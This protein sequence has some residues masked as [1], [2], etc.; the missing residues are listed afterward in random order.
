MA[1][2]CCVIL[3]LPG[4][5]VHAQSAGDTASSVTPDNFV[6]PLQNLDGAVVFTGATGTQAPPGSENIGITLSG[7]RLNGGLPQMAQAGAAL[8]ERLTRGRIPVAELFDA[9]AK[10]EEDYAN[11]GF[12]LVRV[13]LPQQSLRDGGVLQVVVVNG[14]VEAVDKTNV[15]PEIERRLD[16]LTAPLVDRTD[17]TLAELERQL[18]LA[19]DTAGVSLGSA[20]GAGRAPG[21]TVLTLDPEYRKITGF[22][23]F[24]NNVSDNLGALTLNS[25]VE[26]NSPFGFGETFYLRASGTPDRFT[27]SD[28]RFRV[29]AAG[30]LMPLGTSG[31]ALNG[32][33][34]ASD[35][36]PDDPVAP[37]RSNFDRQSL[38]LI[39]PVIRSRQINVTTQVV[40]DRQH[41]RQDLIA[42]GGITPIYEDRT[43]ALRFGGSAN[44][45]HA[46]GAFSDVGAVLSQGLDALGAR[47]LDE[48]GGGT[49]LSR[50]GADAEFSKLSFS[51]F[52]QRALAENVS[53][54]V[55]ARA[56]FAFG[57]PLVTSEQFGLAGPRDLSGFD[58]GELRGDSGWILRAE[59]AHRSTVAV[60]AFP[61]V[62]S[63]YTFVAA[64]G[65]SIE[66]PTAVE[67]DSETAQSFGVGLDIIIQNESRFRAN[68]VRVELAKGEREHG[69]DETRFS[70]SGNFR[71]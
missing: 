51:G 33:V 17:V 10:L 27:S 9:V 22:F 25:G 48:V 43:T 69:T 12:V 61:V 4:P 30:F 11:A 2:F 5:V 21:G 13:V 29:L 3:L 70:I 54:S 14:F 34:T 45:V 65:V 58:S 26:F 50:Q 8:E 63:P 39:Y 19:G 56:Q 35:T 53:L 20:L 28:P 24:D 6:P 71:F 1:V 57:D 52:H 46:D 47:G 16:R 37:T 38:R 49:P 32:E 7:V 67:R 66:E 62:L 15:P 68:S 36:K 42:N 55:T 18:L 59:V 60:A 23:G 44:Y 40:L 41:D 64:G 31:L